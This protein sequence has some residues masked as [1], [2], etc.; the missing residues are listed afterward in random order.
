[1]ALESL[2]VISAERVIAIFEMQ[3]LSIRPLIKEFLG[4][5]SGE[6]LMLP[7]RD[8]L[9]IYELGQPG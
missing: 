1:M 2:T 5:N 7:P 9:K 3:L 8:H 4:W 6:V